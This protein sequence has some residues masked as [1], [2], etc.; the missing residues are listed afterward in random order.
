MRARSSVIV[1]EL[2]LKSRRDG[3]PEGPKRLGGGAVRLAALI[4]ASAA[5]AG[6]QPVPTSIS[7]IQ[8]PSAGHPAFDVRD[9]RGMRWL[10]LLLC[11]YAALASAETNPQFPAGV[12]LIQRIDQTFPGLSVSCL[13]MDSDGSFYI[14]GSKSNS[15]QTL[16]QT[17]VLAKLKPSGQVVFTAQF[18]ATNGALADMI[19]VD[20]SGNLYAHVATI[21]SDF[22]VTA[23]S[24]P[25]PD[26]NIVVL[27]LDSSGALVYSIGLSWRA[28]VRGF[29][30]DSSGKV[31][32]S[33]NMQSGD[34]LPVSPTAFQKTPS[35]SFACAAG[36]IAQ[37][38]AA[39]LAIEAAT[40]LPCDGGNLVL[41]K[42]GDVL[43]AMQGGI[44]AFDSALSRQTL[45]AAG[46]ITP[47]G[48]YIAED[49]SGDIFS[50]NGST[51]WIYS[52]DGS[53]LLAST[54]LSSPNPA[55]SVTASGLAYFWGGATPL[56]PTTN[57]SQPC[58]M[59][60]Q[61]PAS[62]PYPPYAQGLTVIDVAGKIRYATFLKEGILSQSLVTISPADG[63]PYAIGASY[64]ADGTS[65]T[66]IL[67]FD[68][69]GF[70]AGGIFA[71]CLAHSATLISSAIAPGT[72][73]TI[74][75]EKMGP[76]AGVAY[77]PENGRVPFNVAGTTVTVDGMPAPILYAQ[78]GQI[79]FVTP[80]SIRTDGKKIPV[81]AALSGATSCLYAATAPGA[82]GFFSLGNSTAAINE[83]G[84]VN[85][86][87]NPAH[88]GSYV[89]LYLTGAG[90]LTDEVP[91]GGIADLV[92]KGLAASATVKIATLPG[93][94]LKGG[95]CPTEFPADTL[96]V[97][98]VP[99]LTNG[100]QVLII[101]LPRNSYSGSPWVEAAFDAGNLHTTALGHI[102]IAP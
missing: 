89:S 4:P 39:G 70:P 98:W 61:E 34:N 83:D 64:L 48:L 72:L 75:G 56:F 35:S 95:V 46:G 76:D 101:R 22:P 91:D 26:R 58:F 15:P 60:L 25:N 86:Q 99:T 67:A 51:L 57:G 97:G 82:A 16:S 12:E 18:I 69:S 88:P 23:G 37:L 14:G 20:R 80:W 9:V 19:R 85:S 13:T 59:N 54:P 87:N 33:G 92:P 11:C 65:W 78:S 71:G 40:Y 63:R 62:G 79:N 42:N 44:R 36:F 94:C 53:K 55:V 45:P 30:V 41:R 24:S 38:S 5:T 10:P 1:E 17:I 96:Y 27:K 47:S 8:Q 21:S 84:T 77:T 90:P 102:Y 68:T 49:G 3:R 29:E 2:P 100:A 6:A 31:Y 74:I 66:G 7:T 32:L 50:V 28:S 73:M 43:V 93:I 52:P 81:C